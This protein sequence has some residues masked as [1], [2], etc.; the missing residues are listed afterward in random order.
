MSPAAHR[1]LIAGEVAGLIGGIVFALAMQFQASDLAIKGL[2]GFEAVGLDLALHLL[3]ATIAG[4]IFG[5][6]FRHS[7]KGYAALDKQWCSLWSSTL[8]SWP[9]YSQL[10]N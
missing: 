7:P 3:T 2:L 1:D 6:I 8:D 5:L 4:A 9:S 10:F